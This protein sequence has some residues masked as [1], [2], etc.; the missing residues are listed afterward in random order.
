MNYQG[1]VGAAAG[2]SSTAAGVAL[3]PN[4]GGTPILLLVGIAAIVTGVTL[5]SLQF[6]VW[7]Y[8]TR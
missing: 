1:G 6:G 7:F 3:L 5:M 2:V 8:K 4:T